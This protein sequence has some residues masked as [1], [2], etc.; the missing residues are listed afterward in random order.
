MSEL[1]YDPVRC[2][3]DNDRFFILSGCSGGGKSTL[4]QALARAGYRAYPEA[5]RQVFQ[6]QLLIGGDALPQSNPLGFVE[7][8]T[9][10]I[11]YQRAQAVRNGGVALFDRGLIDCQAY[12]EAVKRPVPSWLMRAIEIFAHNKTV[13]MVP[14]WAEI[15]EN[16]AERLHSFEDARRE[17]DKLTEVYERRGYRLMILPRTSVEKRLAMMCP[18]IEMA[19]P[20]N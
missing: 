2:L 16:D 12:L 10:R 13:F 19:H 11:I 5:G 3:G 4:L 18:V 17:Y 7:L 15:Y 20:A 6:E 1:T 14:P 8:V 9:S